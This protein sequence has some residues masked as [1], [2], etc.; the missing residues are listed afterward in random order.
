MRE[1]RE[2]IQRAEVVAP[3]PRERNFL[4]EGRPGPFVTYVRAGTWEDEYFSFRIFLMVKI[5]INYNR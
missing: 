4:P 3:D 2:E 1:L 5:M